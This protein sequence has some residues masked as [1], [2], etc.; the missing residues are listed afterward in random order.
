MPTIIDLGQKVKQKY[1]GVYDDLS[2]VE[3]G[4]KVKQKYPGSYDDF[5]DTPQTPQNKNIFRKVGEAVA[6]P[7]AKAGVQA[8]N[9]AEGT[10]KLL[11]GDVQ[12]ANQSLEKKRILPFVGE[13]APVITGNE[14]FGEQVKK[15]VGTGLDIG[16]TV[17]TGGEA[18]ALKDLAKQGLKQAIKK[19]A[20]MGAKVGAAAGGVGSA[21][22]ALESDKNAGEVIKDTATGAVTGGLFGFVAGGFSAK[23]KFLAPQKAEQLKQKAVDQY[24]KGLEITQKTVREKTETV[25]PKLLEEKRWGTMNRLLDKAEKNLAL[26]EADYSKLGELQGVVSSPEVTS[27]IDELANNLKLNGRVPTVNRGKYKQLMDLKTDIVSMQAYSDLKTKTPQIY[28]QDLRELKAMYDEAIYGSKKAFKTVEESDS[29]SQTKE[30]TDAIR[31]ILATKNPEYAN[32]NKLYHVNKTL[33]DAIETTLDRK[34]AQSWIPLKDVVAAG[35][36]AAA[37]DLKT[38]AKVALSLVSI[39]RIADSTWF[40][41]MSA[42]R[43][44]NVANKLLQ[45]STEE[46][47]R[48]INILS[49]QGAKGV[50]LLFESN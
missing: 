42:V 2:D 35:A 12:G 19:G 37:G 32:I 10:G 43:K 22:I 11:A 4:Q 45:K 20:V 21:G 5:T 41:T 27:K 48:W 31:G 36:S 40:N 29:L 24:V 49:T 17:A 46:I 14:S 39:R 23:K 13:T 7:F 9:L 44:N 26:S 47:P 33:A 3:V 50:S 28:Q 25:I 1:P 16:S 30:V 38:A 8:Y 34:K 18:G 6:Q 15:T